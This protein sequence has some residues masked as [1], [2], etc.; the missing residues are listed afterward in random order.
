[1]IPKIIHQLWEGEPLPDFYVQF[2]QTWK[3]NHP[4]WQYE[5]WDGDRM[6]TFVR[7]HYPQ[8]VNAYR[9]F[10]HNIQRWD[11]VRY[12]ILYKTGGMYADF[13]Y[14]CLLPVDDYMAEEGKCYFAMEPEEH[15]IRFF[16][17]DTFTN[18]LMAT[19]PDHPFFKKIIEHIFHESHHE[20]TNNTVRDVH[21]STGP[22]MLTDLYRNYPH[23]DEIVLWPPELASPWT[24]TEVRCMLNGTADESYLEKKL[25]KA[26]AVH[27]FFSLWAKK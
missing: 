12:L 19:C 21:A 16:G 14:E 13:D 3:E 11:A 18:A 27:Y 20:Y 5:F 1:M 26:F 6:E 23:K 7:I 15:C 2:A 10:R 9:G 4:G 25:E 22:V 17:R 8:F 24:K